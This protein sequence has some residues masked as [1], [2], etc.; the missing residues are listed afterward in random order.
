[1]NNKFKR[2][3]KS[4][5]PKKEEPL[6]DTILNIS[7][8]LAAVVFLVFLC[9]HLIINSALTPKGIK[10]EE[11]SQ[12]KNLLIEN[13]RELGQEIARIRSISIIEEI[14]GETLNLEA[15][16]HDKILYISNE[17]IIAGL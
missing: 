7:I 17:S 16:A 4:I 8:K 11:L 15:N 10:L 13:N 14:T 12:E 6:V 2:Q 1:V 3:L 5:F 9:A